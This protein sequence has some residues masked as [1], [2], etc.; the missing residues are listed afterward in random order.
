MAGEPGRR[1]S[2]EGT[3]PD[4]PHPPV[5]GGRPDALAFDPATGDW[6]PA[7]SLSVQAAG[8]AAAGP[9]PDAPR[10]GPVASLCNVLLAIDLG[11]LGV[12]LLVEAAYALLT[13]LQPARFSSATQAAP[14]QGF[15]WATVAINFT[16]MGVVPFL[17]A[18]GTRAVPV[19]GTLR[20][21]RLDHPLRGIR[22]GAGWGLVTLGALLVVGAVMKVLG[23][24][25]PNPQADAVVKVVTLPLALALA[26]GA[27]VGEELL[28]RGLLQRRLGVWGQAVLFAL[29]HLSYGTP[30]Q[31][32]IP[33]ALGILYGYLVKRGSSLWVPMTAHFLFDFAQLGSALWLGQ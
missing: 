29:F 28:F 30:L 6:L 26:L 32:A 7:A 2:P 20:F 15:L 18:L 24:N 14:T 13:A 3:S 31:V 23:Y 19:R 27:G 25:P 22:V 8:P 17:W 5:S 1:G 11:V 33:F 4:N 9:A 16:C 21:F 12:I 10:R